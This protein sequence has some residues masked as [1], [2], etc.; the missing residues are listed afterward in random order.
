MGNTCFI[1]AVL[2]CFTHTVP[3]V[4]GLRSLNHQEKPCDRKTL[5]LTSVSLFLLE[6]SNYFVLL[7]LSGDIESFCLLCALRDHIELSLNSSGGVVSPSKFFDNLN[8]IPFFF[9]YH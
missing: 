7:E 4:L 9:M 5:T 6:V 2:Q 8:C 1:N 3:F